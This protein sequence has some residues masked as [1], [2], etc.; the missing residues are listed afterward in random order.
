ME[1]VALQPFVSVTVTKYVP[2]N[3]PL[4]SCV[5][6]VVFHKYVYGL[7]PPV[8]LKS[9]DPFKLSVHNGFTVV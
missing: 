2:S 9:I 7:V 8:T 4:M 1:L 6:A 5:V 3:K